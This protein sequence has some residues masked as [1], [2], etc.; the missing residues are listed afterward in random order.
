MTRILIVEDEQSFSEPLSFLLG[1]EGYE[2]EVASDGLAAIEKFN[3]KGADLIGGGNNK[4]F[5]VS[6]LQTIPAGIFIVDLNQKRTGISEVNLR[7]IDPTLT[8]NVIIEMSKIYKNVKL[9]G[10]ESTGENDTFKTLKINYE[11]K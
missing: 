9:L 8:N 7:T 3:K 10:V 11:M 5:D 1:K 4:V 6:F 2:T